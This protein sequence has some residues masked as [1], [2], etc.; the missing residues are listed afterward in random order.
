M[1]QPGPLHIGVQ[2]HYQPE[3][4]YSTYFLPCKFILD[5]PSSKRVEEAHIGEWEGAQIRSC[6][7]AST[8]DYIQDWAKELTL[9]CVNSTSLLSLTT[10]TGGEFTQPRAHSFA[11]HCTMVLNYC[12]KGKGEVSQY[13]VLDILYV[14]KQHSH[15]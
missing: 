7:L 12:N 8:R 11:Q 3:Y 6:A 14:I 4:Y 1:F 2:S 10:G 15:I 13:I 5:W 9:G